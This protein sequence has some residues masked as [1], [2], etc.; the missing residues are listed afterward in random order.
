MEQRQPEQGGE[1]TPNPNEHQAMTPVEGASAWPG[2]DAEPTTPS[3]DEPDPADG[4]EQSASATGERQPTAETLR[5]DPPRIYVASLSDYNA[6]RLH[7][8]WINADQD[9]ESIGAEIAAM[10]TRSREPGA[11]EWAIHDYEGFGPVRL[12]EWENLE[13]VG[14]LA[15]GIAEHGE[16]YAAWVAY[17]G[18]DSADDPDGFLDAYLGRWESVGSYAEQLAEDSGWYQALDEL[19]T[20]MKPYVQIDIDQLSRDLSMDLYVHTRPDGQVEIFDVQ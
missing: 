2:A 9:A 13:R 14:Q 20:S 16:A 7:G 12:G 6:G 5:P 17:V 3:T 15:S 11:E 4:D 1:T 18:I 8:A 10:L 19:P